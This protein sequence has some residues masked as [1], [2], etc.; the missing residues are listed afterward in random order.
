M[1]EIMKPHQERVLVELKELNEKLIKLGAFIGGDIFNAL[2]NEDR[3]LLEE[4]N[5]WM[6]AYCGV[7][8]K[9]VERF[10]VSA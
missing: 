9:R 7:L 2:P 10:S 5:R 1:A 8:R 3:D 6:E 4:Q